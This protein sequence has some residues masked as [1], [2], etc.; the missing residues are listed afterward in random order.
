MAHAGQDV[1]GAQQADVERTGQGRTASDDQAQP[2]DLGAAGHVGLA[3]QQTPQGQ[4]DQGVAN[5]QQG[6]AQGDRT[7]NCSSWVIAI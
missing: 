1:H 4:G 6:V 2:G 7:F 5:H 3:T